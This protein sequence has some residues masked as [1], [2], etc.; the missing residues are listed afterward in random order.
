MI[1]LPSG[2]IYMLAEARSIFRECS[3]LIDPFEHC[4]GLGLAIFA[5]RG[6]RQPTLLSTADEN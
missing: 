3:K 4:I 1:S 5:F 6:K 2:A